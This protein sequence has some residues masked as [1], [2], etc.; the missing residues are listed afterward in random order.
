MHHLIRPTNATRLQRFDSGR[1]IPDDGLHGVAFSGMV[2]TVP[3]AFY[4]RC[5]CVTGIP[6]STCPQDLA[7][8]RT[9]ERF[10]AAN[11]VGL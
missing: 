3:T 1:W 5:Q 7:M 4:P 6:G 8:D 2:G 11:G 9:A 10:G